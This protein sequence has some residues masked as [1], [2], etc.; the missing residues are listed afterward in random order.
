M[1]LSEV[2]NLFLE[3]IKKIFCRIK[4]GCIFAP[5]FGREGH[6]RESPEA[7]RER[8]YLEKDLEDE[9]ACVTAPVRFGRAVRHETSQR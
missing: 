6:L 2:T 3:I 1:C 9:I 5:A 4:K 7:S 8:E